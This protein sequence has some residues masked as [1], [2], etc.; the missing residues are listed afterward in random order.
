MIVGVCVVVALLIIGFPA[1]QPSRTGGSSREFN[2]LDLAEIGAA[3]RRR[4]RTSTPRRRPAAR[5]RP[6][7]RAGSPTRTRRRPSAPLDDV[8]DGIERKFYTAD[9]R[10]EVESARA[11]PRARLHDPLVRR[12]HRRRRRDRARCCGPRQQ[13]R[14]QR[15]PASKFMA[16]PWT[17]RGRRR[18]PRRPA[19]RLHALVGRR[20]RRRAASRS[21]SG[22]T[23]PRPA[24]RRWRRS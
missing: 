3:A 6:A 15:Q 13:V 8:W 12:D 2:D 16:A 7:G 4:A 1:Y 17:V 18:V 9:D 24:A 5:P 14:R 23:A 11:Q 19:R 10:P 21:A 20:R 22:S